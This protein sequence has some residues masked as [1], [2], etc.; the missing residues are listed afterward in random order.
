MAQPIKDAV[1]LRKIAIQIKKIRKE[2]EITQDI[3][4]YDT[5]IHIAGIET[6]KVDLSLS[7]LKAICNYFEMSLVEFF[8]S[9]EVKKTRE[10]ILQELWEKRN[11]AHEENQGTGK[12]MFWE[13][14][15]CVFDDLRK[16]EQ[17]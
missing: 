4:F 12:D 14:V 6:G 15:L 3:F 10:E 9:V 13:T 8:D 11:P 16:A 7:A 1:L 5:N 2:R 17:S